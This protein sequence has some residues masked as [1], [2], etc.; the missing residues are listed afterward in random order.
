MRGTNPRFEGVVRV[1][2]PGSRKRVV[3]RPRNTFQP[4]R[5]G[6]TQRGKLIRPLKRRGHSCIQYHSRFGMC[7]PND[8]KPPRC[9]RTGTGLKQREQRISR[10]TVAS[11]ASEKRSLP[12]V[13]SRRAG[14][15]TSRNLTFF[16]NGKLVNASISILKRSKVMPLRRNARWT[17]GLGD[18]NNPILRSLIRAR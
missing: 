1:N 3:L 9:G 8:R 16:S 10:T 15:C 2:R 13:F 12:L 6:G 7:R 17:L 14:L 5:T 11:N 18:R 4:E